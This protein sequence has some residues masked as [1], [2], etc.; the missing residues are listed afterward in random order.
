MV[1]KLSAEVDLG[2]HVHVQV[3]E[4]PLEDVAHRQEAQHAVIHVGVDGGHAWL[5]HQDVAC[6]IVV[7]QH[8]ALGQAGGAGGVDDGGELGGVDGVAS[9]I[10]LGL[11]GVGTGLGHF[12]PMAGDLHV[13]KR[14][15]LLQGGAFCLDRHDLV[16]E[17][18]VADKAV[19]GL[20]VGEDVLVILL[21]HGG[22]N[23]HVDAAGLHDAMVHDVPLATV[24]VADEGHLVLG[25]HAQSDEPS[26]HGVHLL[27][28]LGGG[29]RD[30]V[31]GI[32]HGHHHVQWLCGQ[33]V[34]WEIEKACG[35][36]H[37]LGIERR[38]VDRAA[39]LGSKIHT[40]RQS[41]R[42]KSL[43]TVLAVR[44]VVVVALT[45]A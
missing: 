45:S 3:V 33:L 4:H 31:A 5:C 12:R 6:H 30:A 28:K 14:E 37:G 43:A 10:E 44:R 15:H 26:R 35:L 24:V 7:R 23:R 19:L 22:V 8:H 29:I 1:S 34:T 11:L 18:L 21:R 41:R 39:G 20:A 25:L 40:T 17:F 36:V 32:G 42:S 38:R 27:H 16:V 13:F 9:G 2:P